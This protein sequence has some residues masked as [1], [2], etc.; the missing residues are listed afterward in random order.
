M[1]FDKNII[2]LEPP[3]NSK[4]SITFRVGI[5]TVK[6]DAVSR[7]PITKLNFNLISIIRIGYEIKSQLSLGIPFCLRIATR[8]LETQSN[9]NNGYLNFLVIDFQGLAERIWLRVT[10][11]PE[12]P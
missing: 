5:S 8:F 4:K 9:F 6:S 1:L 10:G 7:N 3:L 12:T 11:F 2:F